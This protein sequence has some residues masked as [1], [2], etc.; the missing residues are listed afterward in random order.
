MGSSVIKIK[1]STKTARVVS[2]IVVAF[3][4]SG[5]AL[6]ISSIPQSASNDLAPLSNNQ[7]VGQTFVAQNGGLN[8]VEFYLEPGNDLNGLI[9]IHLRTDAK[10]AEDIIS[11]SVEI[12]QING[13]GF[14]RFEFQPQAD[15]FRKYYYVFLELE[16]EGTLWIGTAPGHEY[17][18]GALYLD[19]NPENQQS[20]FNLVY[21]PGLALIDFAREILYWCMILLAAVFLFV[22]PG[23]AIVSFAL[24][25]SKEWG[26]ISRCVVGVGISLCLY[27]ILFLLTDL[28]GIRLGPILAWAP[29]IIGVLIL[30]WR[31]FTHLRTT[32]VLESLSS[33]RHSDDLSSVSD[34]SSPESLI[35]PYGAT[36]SPTV[37]WHSCWSTTRA[38]SNPGLHMQSYRPL[39]ITLDFTLTA[40]FFT[41]S[42]KFLSPNPPFGWGKSSIS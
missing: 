30:V 39:P 25:T 14:Y 19:H 21:H 22:I 36:R 28:S 40:L 37:W 27:P 41:G 29:G 4:L 1:G 31:S 5:C 35:F 12:S 9:R 33:W 11:S 16:G 34:S 38:Y 32:N 2:W 3:L 15:S 23:L 10:R 24:P 17:L 18:D 6:S 20:V 13:A 26:W 7:S 42:H 8:G